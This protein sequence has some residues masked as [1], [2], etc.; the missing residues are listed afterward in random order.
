MDYKELIK[1][2]IEARALAYVPY[3]NFRV[4]AAILTEDNSIYN[5][6]NIENASYGATNC[7]ERTA[8]FKAVSEGK[9]KIKAIAVIGRKDEFTYPC[10]IC[11]QVIAEFADKDTIV[12]L[13]KNIDEYEVKTLEEI[14]PGAFTQKDLNI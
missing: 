6:C 1:K 10:G 7:A 4:G 9:T 2:A 3:S 13:A 14:F 12:I 5:G 11:R 8:I